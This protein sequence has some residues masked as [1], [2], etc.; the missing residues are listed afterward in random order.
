MKYLSAKKTLFL[1]VLNTVVV[2]ALWVLPTVVENMIFQKAVVIALTVIGVLLAIAFYIVNGLSSSLL[3]GAYEK[4][5]YAHLK[6]GKA[7]DEGQN[8]RYNPFKLSLCRRIY[9][10]KLLLVFLFPIVLVYLYECVMMLIEM[11]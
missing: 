11:L 9:Y 5:Y 7:L 10:A 1:L 6:N 2:G 8:L 3:E 4:E